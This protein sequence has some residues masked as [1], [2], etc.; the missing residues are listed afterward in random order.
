MA[1]QA[2]SSTI[3][4]ATLAGMAMTVV[5]GAVKTWKPELALDPTLVSGSTMLASGIVG[6][7]KKENVLDLKDP[8]GQ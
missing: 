6:Y 3:K 7:L 5:W 1:L 8:A 4:A 2:P